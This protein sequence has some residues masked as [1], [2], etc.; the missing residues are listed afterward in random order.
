M[1]DLD[2][3]Q[4][5]F[6]LNTSQK[7]Y[8]EAA[9]WFRSEEPRQQGRTVLQAY[10]II[11]EALKNPG[12]KIRIGADHSANKDRARTSTDLLPDAIR[13]IFRMSNMHDLEHRSKVN[14][15]FLIVYPWVCG[16]CHQ[17]ENDHIPDKKTPASITKLKCPFASTTF[18]KGFVGSREGTDK[19]GVVW[20]RHFASD[21]EP[22]YNGPTGP[23]GEPNDSRDL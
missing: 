18:A 23:D 11:E 17:L 10:I 7:R 12:I 16:V 9:R 21:R 13:R 5:G 22:K 4:K 8:L 19:D 14:E 2:R 3:L 20:R 1:S 15:D 6:I